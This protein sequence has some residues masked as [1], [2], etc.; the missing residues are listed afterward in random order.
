MLWGL[1]SMYIDGRWSGHSS[2]S[3]SSSPQSRGCCS[4]AWVGRI[5]VLSRLEV[6]LGKHDKEINLEN[7]YRMQYVM[8]RS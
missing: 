8:M 4:P 6:H 3:S 5:P 1:P 2:K 7:A